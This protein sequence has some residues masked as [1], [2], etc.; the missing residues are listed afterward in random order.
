MAK[1]DPRIVRLSI[2][3]QGQLKIYEGL[4]IRSTGCKYA[5]P[6]QNEAQVEIANLTQ[7]DRDYIL[8]ATSPYNK[9]KTPKILILEAGRQSTGY[10]Q[11]YKGEISSCVPTQPP[12]I[13][14]KF[15]C[16]ANQFLKGNII[17]SAQPSLSTLK[18]IA[19]QAAADNA[20]Q[21]RFEATDKNVSNYTFTGPSINQV[22]HVAALGAID[23]YCDDDQLVVKDKNVP[24]VGQMRVLDAQSGMVGI[25]ELTEQGLKVTYLLD[26]TT[27]LGGAL[28]IHSAV[29]PSVN[30]NYVIYKLGWNVTSRDTPFYWIAECVRVDASG[31]L[32]I[33]AGLKKKKPKG[34]K[35]R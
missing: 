28:Q 26:N 9:D 34:G 16:K 8:T 15:K 7:A 31:A 2:Q 12:D 4:D 11:I 17:S 20:L 3:V 19:A 35:R 14:L 5:N 6:L 10:T 23:C 32:E 24:L 30:G 13:V 21:L 27:T 18:K 1:I 33:P 25:P 22:E 29:Y